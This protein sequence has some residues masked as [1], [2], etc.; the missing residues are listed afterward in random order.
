MDLQV[1][2][3]PGVQQQRQLGRVS[4][5]RPETHNVGFFEALDPQHFLQCRHAPVFFFSNG[6]RA[7]QTVA[8]EIQEGVGHQ[9]MALHPD[10]LRIARQGGG[11]GSAVGRRRD[12]QTG[13]R[14][15][16]GGALIDIGETGRGT[17][18]EDRQED[19]EALAVACGARLPR[20]HQL[21]GGAL[22]LLES[23]RHYLVRHI[24]PQCHKCMLTQINRLPEGYH[25]RLR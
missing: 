24:V 11:E 3:D 12:Q 19:G 14:L 20:R 7:V 15:V 13:G 22:S 18:Q 16:D 23:H 17:G 4:A 25:K 9:G 5:A 8:Q 21:I 1:D 2:V 6:G 10:G